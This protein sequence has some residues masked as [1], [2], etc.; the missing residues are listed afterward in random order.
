MLFSFSHSTGLKIQSESLVY[1]LKH[2]AKWWFNEVEVFELAEAYLLQKLNNF[3]R[4]ESLG[5]Y[6]DYWKITGYGNNIACSKTSKSE[7]SLSGLKKESF[8][9][10][11]TKN[12]LSPVVTFHSKDKLSLQKT[13]SSPHIIPLKIKKHLPSSNFWL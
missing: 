3:L 6:I 4:R 12:L 9:A 10:T 2:I 13:N 7:M 8:F 5:L 11:L 1:C